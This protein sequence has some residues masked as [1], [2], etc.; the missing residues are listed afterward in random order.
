M[1]KI[2]VP[3]SEL[4]TAGAAGAATK[5]DNSSLS[6]SPSRFLFSLCRLLFLLSLSVSKSEF[7]CCGFQIRG[8]DF[9]RSHEAHG[10]AMIVGLNRGFCR[11]WWVFGHGGGCL[12][13]GL[14]I[15]A[16][17]IDWDGANELMFSNFTSS[18]CK[19]KVKS[20]TFLCKTPSACVVQA[21]QGPFCAVTGG[22]NRDRVGVI[23]SREKHKGS[24]ETV[25]I[26]DALGHEFANP[27]WNVF[28]VGKG[29]KAMGLSPQGQ[30]SC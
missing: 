3:S 7:G 8:G 5:L 29:H 25:H 16:L 20:E 15:V 18:A 27:S 21:L 28:T 1:A 6:L 2:L 10:L 12:A 9:S 22:R 26:Q 4:C 24:F 19:N 14:V 17:I 13:M 30:G 11:G 23:K